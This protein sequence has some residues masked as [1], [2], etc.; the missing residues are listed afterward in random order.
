MTARLLLL[1]DFDDARPLSGAGRTAGGAGALS[2]DPA[3][4]LEEE[5]LKAYESG[6][7]AGWEDATAAMNGEQERIG[8]ELARH[9]QE[10]SFTYREAHAALQVELIEVVRGIVGKVLTPSV[11]LALGALIEERVGGLAAQPGARVEICVAPGNVARVERLA[12]AAEAPPLR[13]LPEPSL[14]PGQAFLRFGAA[15]EQID[16][17]TILE[18]IAEAVERHFTGGG[19]APPDAETLEQDL[20]MERMHG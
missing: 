19:T 12:E 3:V 17:D 16:L 14:G 7:G 4:D 1:E 6:Y 5:R 11:P 2:P 8:A 13:I 18:E 15:E 9:L 20:S 10:L